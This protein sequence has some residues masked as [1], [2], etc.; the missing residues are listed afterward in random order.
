MAVY[1][2]IGIAP[3]TFVADEDLTSAQYRFVTV[4][5]T[6]GYIKLATGASNP[7]PIGVLQNSP[8]LGQEASVMVIGFT[9]L[10]ARDSSTCNVRYGKFITAS[11]GGAAYVPDTGTGSAHLGRW[12]DANITTSAASAIGQAFVNCGGFGSCGLAAS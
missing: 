11:A 10:V 1:K 3:A 5:S 6:P 9:K 8:S 2:N 7:M 12:L 4:A